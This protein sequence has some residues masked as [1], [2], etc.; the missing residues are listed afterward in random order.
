MRSAVGFGFTLASS[1]GFLGAAEMRFGSTVATAEDE[2]AMSSPY[3][4]STRQLRA[5]QGESGVVSALRASYVDV[6][7]D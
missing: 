5:W 2:E 4:D 7:A 3:V 6:Y 1:C